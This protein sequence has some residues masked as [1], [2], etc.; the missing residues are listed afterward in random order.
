V[1]DHQLTGSQIRDYLLEVADLLPSAG[2]Q[3]IVVVGGSLLAVLGFREATTDVDSITPLPPSLQAAVAEVATRHDLPPRWLNDSAVQFLPSTFDK[4][5]C[6]VV[7]DHPRL[8]VLGAPLQQVFVMKLYAARVVDVA[9]LTAIW[10]E[11]G[12]DSPEEAAA[13]FQ[14]A[15]PHLEPDEYL[16]DFIREIASRGTASGGSN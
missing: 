7:I 14:S 5:E 16:A 9:D 15:Y 11:C 1:S 8:K 13:S 2:P 4:V 3:C 6:S 10:S 12:F